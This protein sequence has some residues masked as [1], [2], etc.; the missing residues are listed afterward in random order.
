YAPAA[1]AAA[2]LYRR[3]ERWDALVALEL[4]AAERITDPRRRAARILLAGERTELRLGKLEAAK[5]LYRRALD[6][7]PGARGALEALDRLYRQ[8]G[9]WA[10][11]A[12]LY[13]S[14]AE[15]AHDRALQRLFHLYAGQIARERVVDPEAAATHFGRAAELDAT[16]LAPLMALSR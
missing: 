3:L 14:Q 4:E 2:A 12:T 13:A 10:E 7:D 5:T 1:E 6:L 16:D 15:R 11:L 9:R 8:D